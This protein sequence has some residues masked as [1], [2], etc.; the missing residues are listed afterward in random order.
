MCIYMTNSR[1][2]TIQNNVITRCQK[3][4][5]AVFDK[6]NFITVNDNL[7]A[8]VQM[9]ADARSAGSYVYTAGISS[10]VANIGMVLSMRNNVV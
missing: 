7:V 3:Y 10:E 5:V 8:G 1:N 6:N 2:V 9:W 4:G